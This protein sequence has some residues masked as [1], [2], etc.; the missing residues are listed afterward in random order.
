MGKHK[1]TFINHNSV[2]SVAYS[3][4]GRTIAGTNSDD[5]TV[6]LW[7]AETGKHKTTLKGHP[8]MLLSDESAP[9][10]YSPNGRTLASVSFNEVWLWDVATGKHKA[11]LIGHPDKVCSVACSPD[12]RTLASVSR[13]TDLEVDGYGP[14]YEVR[15]WDIV[16]GEHKTTLS[17]GA[18][19]E[20]DHFI[21]Q[22]ECNEAFL[23][24]NGIS[25]VTFS[26]DG[27][28]IATGGMDGT[29]LL[30]DTITE[31][32]RGTLTGHVGS[33]CSITYSPC[34]MLQV[35]RMGQSSCGKPHVFFTR[36]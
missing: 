28:T 29:I 31:E 14:I 18:Y 21:E 36:P 7:D 33:I 12:G 16:T 2:V 6:S 5:S 25:S 1:A 8:G 13:S 24:D 34:G 30:W 26:P 23:T 32:H 9:M 15:L 10:T 4:D 20:D 17:L 19:I 35:A 22:P 3:P 11:T 27:S